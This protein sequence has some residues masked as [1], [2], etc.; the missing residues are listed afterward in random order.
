MRVQ[1]SPMH[2]LSYFSLAIPCSWHN[3]ILSLLLG[4]YSPRDGTS[5]RPLIDSRVAC[6]SASIVCFASSWA[7]SHGRSVVLNHPA[8]RR[9]KA[10]RSFRTTRTVTLHYL[11]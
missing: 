2:N 10:G 1:Q 9:T 3:A 4:F 7:V 5:C 11:G 6:L 8:V